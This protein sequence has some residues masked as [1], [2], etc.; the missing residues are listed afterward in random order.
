MYYF[1]YGTGWYSPFMRHRPWGYP[2]YR[3]V[4]VT[5]YDNSPSSPKPSKSRSNAISASHEKMRKDKEK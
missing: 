5:R 3:R 2:S 1:D 4:R